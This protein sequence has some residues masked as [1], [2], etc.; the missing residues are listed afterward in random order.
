MQASKLILAI[1]VCPAAA[2]KSEG[3][4]VDTCVTA[5]HSCLMDMLKTVC[6]GLCV[7][8]GVMNHFV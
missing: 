2:R 5:S 4:L 7:C 3:L 8:G 1:S 6:K